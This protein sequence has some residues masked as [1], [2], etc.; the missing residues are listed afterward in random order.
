M[1]EWKVDDEYLKEQIKKGKKLGDLFKD[2]RLKYHGYY[3]IAHRIRYWRNIDSNFELEY[4]KAESSY[5]KQY[6]KTIKLEVP[7]KWIF[8]VISDNHL[9]STAQRLDILYKCYNEFAKA[10]IK[11]VF[12]AGD[13]VD[14]WTV[15]KGQIYYVNRIGAKP[16]I[17]YLIEK[18]PYKKDMIT[19]F[20]CGN[21]DNSIYRQ[22]SFNV[23]EEF[24]KVRKDVK[25]IGLYRGDIIVKKTKIRLIHPQGGLTERMS[26]LYTYINRLP[27]KDAPDYL[28]CGHW[29]RKGLIDI[30]GINVLLCRTTQ[31]ETPYFIERGL[32]PS[33]GA[34]IIETTFDNKGKINKFTPYE[35]NE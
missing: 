14:G 5:R 10:G 13:L 18:Y 20:I 8:G 28:F 6:T 9:N 2:N 19:Y 12:N 26:T 30:R 33:L 34:Y 23:G 24:E 11:I 25:Y 31:D 4:L 1:P 35:I 17:D 16:Q 32:V 21:H 15:Y 29:H 3:G 27:F 22:S 7:N